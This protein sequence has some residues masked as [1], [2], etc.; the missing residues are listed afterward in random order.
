LIAFKKGRNVFSPRHSS[1]LRKVNVSSSGGVLN[2]VLSFGSDR[3][4]IFRS[5]GY[6]F[7]VIT[8]GKIKSGRSRI[9]LIG[10]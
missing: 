5:V 6:G 4:E 9:T 7:A 2:L 3:E 10:C 8:I 1:E